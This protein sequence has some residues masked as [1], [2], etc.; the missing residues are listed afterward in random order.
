[1]TTTSRPP[2]APAPT[3]D[4]GWARD[5]GTRAFLIRGA[6]LVGVGYAIGGLVGAG[7]AGA[8]VATT[9][10]RPASLVAGSAAV[11]LVVSGFATV[12]EV[13]PEKG[14]LRSNF[15][16]VRPVASAC[17]LAAGVLAIVA[18][19]TLAFRERATSGPA[20]PSSATAAGSPLSR[21]RQRISGARLRA[22][23]PFAAILGVTLVVRIALLPAVPAALRE[24]I[25]NLRS[26][27]GYV[28]G[29]SG[30]FQAT[31]APSPVPAVLGAFAPGGA[32]LTLLLASVAI[33]GLTMALTHFL[34]GRRAAALAGLA[35]LV[36][37]VGTHQTLPSTLAAA[38]LLGSILLGTDLDRPTVRAALAGVAL[39]LAILCLP[40][41]VLAAPLLVGW[42][43]F[44]RSRAH[45]GSVGAAATA[46]AI[47]VLTTV[48]WLRYL[49]GRFHTLQPSTD[50]AFGLPTIAAFLPLAVVATAV[51]VAARRRHPPE[52]PP[53]EAPP[54]PP[55]P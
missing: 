30:S 52:A 21:A 19:T 47:A 54:T 45:P 20:A 35:V 53:T 50:M 10:R 43:G 49:S 37:Q 9:W 2:Q 22:A 48:P 25:A 46:L 1:M 36:L 23:A 5:G 34:A 31:G 51:L 40:W 6:V 27:D 24:L 29:R 39:G 15:A 8:G 44:G 17:G 38:L 13:T 42:I 26:G 4:E 3:A 12:F 28:L 7:V 41:T 18:V 32:G 14:S 16:D 11:M 55:E 33:V